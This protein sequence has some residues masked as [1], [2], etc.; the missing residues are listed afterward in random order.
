M[1]FAP[2]FSVGVQKK[3]RLSSLYFKWQFS[4]FL[5]DFIRKQIKHY[6]MINLTLNSEGM[7]KLGPKVVDVLY[8][9]PLFVLKVRSFLCIFS[10]KRFEQLWMELWMESGLSNVHVIIFSFL[11]KAIPKQN[12]VVTKS[13]KNVC[14]K[15]FLWKLNHRILKSNFYFHKIFVSSFKFGFTLL[16]DYG[17]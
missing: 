2:L 4:E 17:S 16:K 15:Y 8:G 9:R 7:V 14:L 6:F 1:D 11:F 10:L 13:S 12:R 3:K 5:T